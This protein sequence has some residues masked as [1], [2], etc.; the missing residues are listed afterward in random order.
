MNGGLNFIDKDYRFG[1]A[2]NLTGATFDTN[3]NVY[4][5]LRI[6]FCDRTSLTT[7]HTGATRDA[8]ISNNKRHTILSSLLK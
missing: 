2:V 1:W 5:G 3:R 6:A 4:M 8:F 7:S